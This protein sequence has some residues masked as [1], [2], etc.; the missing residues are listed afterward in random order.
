[1]PM[2]YFILNAIVPYPQS[3]PP[4]TSRWTPSTTRE[5]LKLYRSVGIE[6]P[7]PGERIILRKKGIGSLSVF[8]FDVDA[9]LILIKATSQKKAYLIADP[10]KAYFSA[11]A[12]KYSPN[13]HTFDSLVEINSMPT[14]SM[15]IAQILDMCQRL[16]HYRIDTEGVARELFSGVYVTTDEIKAACDLT[17]RA[18]DDPGLVHA[19]QHLAQSHYLLSGFM[20]GS[21]YYHHY[22][23]DRRAERP[24]FRQKKYLENRTMYDLAFLSA[25]RS[26]EA[27]LG[28]CNISKR[29]IPTLLK[30]LD[31]KHAT[32]F[33]SSRWRSFHE[34][35]SGGKKTVPYHEIIEKHLRLR[36]AVAAH[37]N[38]QPPFDLTEDN[39]F[40]IQNLAAS[41]ITQVVRPDSKSR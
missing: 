8:V 31:A 30:A 36:N 21:Y 2:R 38:T 22:R 32:T 14:A 19:L 6:P 12:G 41:M 39:V 3:S 4:Y 29:D 17:S 28:K 35:F 24:Y 23:H 10:I 5:R 11:F 18:L 33:S 37:G 13:G 34:V 27:T 26:I 9:S 7:S 40:E 16:S 1:M 25:F 20:V 15:T